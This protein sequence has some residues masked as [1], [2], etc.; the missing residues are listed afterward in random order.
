[1]SICIYHRLAKDFCL[2]SVRC[3]LSDYNP[4]PHKQVSEETN[5]KNIA[6]TTKLGSTMML[7]RCFLK[8]RQGHEQFCAFLSTLGTVDC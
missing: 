2:K 6:D 1:M 3:T 7:N 4:H 5:E 8:E